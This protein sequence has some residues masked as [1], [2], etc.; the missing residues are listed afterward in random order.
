MVVAV[1]KFKLFKVCKELNVGI[2][3]VSSFLSEKGIKIKGPNTSFSEEIYLEI[4]ENFA[5]EKEIADKLLRRKTKQDIDAQTIPG[6]EELSEEHIVEKSV[7]VQAIERS[8]EERVEEIIKK[9]DDNEKIK[10][11]KKKILHTY[12]F[13][14]DIYL[15]ILSL[16]FILFC[17]E[18][19]GNWL[20]WVPIIYMINITIMTGISISQLRIFY[21]IV[22]KNS[23]TP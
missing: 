6:E 17:F 7:Y 9:E 3:T 13:R 21:P 8:I 16:I 14:F 22:I 19:K 12:W 20:N 11:K 15:F 4:L 23:S 5:R 18:W 2:E 10:S 1:K